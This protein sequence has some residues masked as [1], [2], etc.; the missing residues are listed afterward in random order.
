VYGVIIF[1][2]KLFVAVM[3]EL[4]LNCSERESLELIKTA[5]ENTEGVSE[6]FSEG[7]QVVAKTTVGFPRILWS[8]GEKLF[9]DIS[10]ST[11]DNQTIVEISAEK[12][13]WLNIGANP[14]KF[15]RKFI[16]EA[17]RIRDG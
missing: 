12:E 5:L 10:D 1:A 4:V 11:N 2:W 13:V 14:E 8:Y 9:I 7:R 6:Y 3:A 15:K 17:D 16:S